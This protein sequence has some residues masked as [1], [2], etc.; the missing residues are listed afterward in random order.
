MNRTIA[1]PIYRAQKSVFEL[2]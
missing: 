1:V 2:S